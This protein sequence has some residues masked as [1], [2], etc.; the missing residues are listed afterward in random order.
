MNGTVR[1]SVIRVQQNVT[2]GT[3]IIPINV[4][5]DDMDD[6]IKFSLSHLHFLLNTTFKGSFSAIMF[7]CYISQVHVCV[8]I[9]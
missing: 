5:D 3:S 9:G 7:W 1:H 8:L 6:G 2:I 4:K